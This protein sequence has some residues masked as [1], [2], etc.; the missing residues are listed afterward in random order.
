MKSI[1]EVQRLTAKVS[2]LEKPEISYLSEGFGNYNY[3][4]QEGNRK[5]VLRIKKSKEKQFSDS[6]EREYI[7]LKYFRTN[8]IDFCPEVYFY[9]R[10]DDFLIESYLEGE[11]ILQKSFSDTQI[12]L[13][14]AQLYKIFTVDVSGF[15]TFCLENKCKVFDYVSPLVSLDTYGFKRFEKAKHDGLK[16]SVQSWIDTK[17][18]EN[19]KYLEAVSENK[20]VRGFAWGDIQSD[21]IVK[22]NDS[23]Y[24]YDFEHAVISNNFGL[25]YIKIHGSFNTSQF[26]YLVERCA[27]YFNTTVSKLL[28]EITAEEKITRVNDVVWAAMMWAETE[29]DTFEKIMEKRMSLAEAL[30]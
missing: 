2:F 27:F 24:F 10:K 7:F 30:Y 23:M 22:N 6:L 26:D 11:K 29:D 4:V 3:L 9:D 19:L 14:A 20:G 18:K 16:Q 21:V 25:S 13:F 28:K 8:G 17:L 5:Y 1:T 15:P 12:D